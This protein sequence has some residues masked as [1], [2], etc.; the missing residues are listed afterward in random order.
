[1]RGKGEETVRRLMRVLQS[2]QPIGELAGVAYREASRPC[3]TRPAPVIRNLDAYRIGWELIC[4]GHYSYWAGLRAAVVQFSRGRPHLCDYCG[5]RGFWTRRRHR[6]PVRFAQELARL[7]RDHGVE[8]IN[9][10][11]ENTTVSKKTW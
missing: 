6:D 9:F 7:H 5:Q 1:V 11:N 2:R 8:V 4:H 10:A 3:A